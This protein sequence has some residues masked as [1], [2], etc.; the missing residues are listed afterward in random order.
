LFAQWRRCFAADDIN[1]LAARDLIEPRAE[2]G[3]G[4]EPVRVSGQ[5]DKGGWAN[6]LGQFAGNGPVGARRMDEVEM[7]SD[8]F[9]ESILGCDAGCSA[10]S[11]SRSVCSISKG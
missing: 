3:I 4:R 11:S 9:G 1:G 5:I 7:A 6:F 8:D 10:A 2:D